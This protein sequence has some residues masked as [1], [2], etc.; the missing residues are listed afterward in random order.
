MQSAY[1]EYSMI[2][3]VHWCASAHV[4]RARGRKDE[5]FKIRKNVYFE[6]KE[7]IIWYVH[8]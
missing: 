7:L 6:E 3:V 1:I 2:Q 4:K 8:P 5:K